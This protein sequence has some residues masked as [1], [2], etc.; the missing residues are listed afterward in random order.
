MVA[1]KPFSVGSRVVDSLPF[2]QKGDAGQAVAL[3]A[4]GVDGVALYLGAANKALADA[5][6]AAGLGVF[7]VT[8]GGHFDRQA[9]VNQAQMLGLP[10]GT[11]VFLDYEA[12]ADRSDAGA[13][14]DIALIN[15][16]ADTVAHAGYVPGIY[17]APAQPLTSEELW[18]LR[19]VRYWKGGGRLIDR[20][21]ALAEPE[22]GWCMFQ[23]WPSVYFGGVWVDANITCHD[24]K[25][26]TVAMAHA[27]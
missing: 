27:A 6:I 15:K 10:P 12:R 25:D 19:V 20:H 16:W 3:K 7:G 21:G 18:H 22:C 9:A 4:S 13:A 17:V 23:M 8:F 14:A 5:C 26:R 1:A 2:S 24:Y 11:S